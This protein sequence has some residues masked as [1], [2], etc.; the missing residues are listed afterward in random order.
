MCKDCGLKQP[1]FGLLTKGKKWWCSFCAKGSSD[2]FGLLKDAP[3][4]AKGPKG[5]VD[6]VNR[7]SGQ[8]ATAAAAIRKAKGVEEEKVAKKKAAQQFFFSR[9]SLCSQVKE[10]I[11]R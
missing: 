9:I 4:G 10:G 5:A 1:S 7:P 6:L 8:L 2:Y 11:F 3:A